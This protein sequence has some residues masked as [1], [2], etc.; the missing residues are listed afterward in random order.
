MSSD[1]IKDI[2]D[3][4]NNEPPEYF[5][6]D[7][8]YTIEI[9]PVPECNGGGFASRLPYFGEAI[10][11]FGFTEAEAIENMRQV[12]LEVFTEMLK[13]GGMILSEYP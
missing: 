10:I 12:Q 7:C 4:I 5:V 1:E 6:R 9:T 13:G 3:R 8:K 2:L 11:G